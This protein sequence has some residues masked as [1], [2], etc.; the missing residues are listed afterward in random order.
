MLYKNLP[1]RELAGVMRVRCWLDYIAAA[2][3]ALK[4]QL[5]MRKRWFVPV[6]NSSCYVTVSGMQE[7]RISEKLPHTLFPNG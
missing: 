4:G 5:P 2:T 3:F 7:R 6:A 1:D